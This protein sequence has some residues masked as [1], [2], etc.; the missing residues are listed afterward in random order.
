MVSTTKTKAKQRPTIKDIAKLVGVHHSTVSR[1]LNRRSNSQISAK[2]TKKV[3]EAAKNLGYYPNIAASSLK[4]N[5]SFAIGM[6][7]PDLLNPVFPPIIRGIQD[8]TDQFNYSLITANTDDDEAKEYRALEMMRSRSLDGIIIATARREDKIVQ[9]CIENHIPFV[10]VN[11]SVDSADVNAVLLD[12]EFGV[13]SSLDHLF[14]LGHRKIAHIAGPIFSS[15]G[16]ERAEAFINYM[17][18]NN[19]DS[20]LVEYTNK[21]TIDEGY[22]AFRR[23]LARNNEFTAVH[24][25]SDVCALG[26]MDAMSEMGLSIPQNISIIGNNDIPFLS[27]MNPALTTLS[28]PKYEMGR[29]AAT[30]LLNVIEDKVEGTTVIRLQPRLVVRDSTGTASV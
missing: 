2:I 8:T 24:V 3:K 15:T 16:Y 12:E 30:I 5:R 22:G 29:Q 9:A 21:F 26:C 11:R 25:C 7:I 14:G 1:V 6:L 10:L 19:L 18:L 28:I 17:K 27:R 20:S 13:R 4:H 23:L